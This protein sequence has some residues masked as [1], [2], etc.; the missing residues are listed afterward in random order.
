M[1]ATFRTVGSKRFR[2]LTKSPLPET[3]LAAL[4]I[5]NEAWLTPKQSNSLETTATP[6]SHLTSW[7]YRLPQLGNL[8]VCHKAIIRTVYFSSYYDTL[9]LLFSTTARRTP[10]WVSVPPNFPSCAT[11]A[12]CLK[13]YDLTIEGH[14][15]IE[16]FL[17]LSM[18]SLTPLCKIAPKYRHTGPQ[19]QVSNQI[20][21]GNATHQ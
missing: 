1:I 16:I 13:R 10:I 7:A 19:R 3:V 11:R 12:L 5:E 4:L 6:F 9:V 8:D 15:S 21:G 18:P 20:S 17:P 2:Q 14:K